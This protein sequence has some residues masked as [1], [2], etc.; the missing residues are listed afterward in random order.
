MLL[1][2]LKIDV[3]CDKKGCDDLSFTSGTFVLWSIRSFQ[4]TFIWWYVC[5]SNGVLMLMEFFN[6]I[7]IWIWFLTFLCF[8]SI[9]IDSYYAKSIQ[10]CRKILKLD[11]EIVSYQRFFNWG[12][13]MLKIWKIS[14]EPFRSC[15]LNSKGN[16]AQFVWK[17]FYP[18]IFTIYF[19]CYRQCD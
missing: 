15:L 16:P 3:F 11:G 19:W 7:R 14:W 18:H 4:N 13:N 6:C 12:K 17:H 10:G 5:L 9:T 2:S 1:W 8:F